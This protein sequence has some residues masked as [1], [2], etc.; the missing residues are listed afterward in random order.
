MQITSIMSITR[1]R[2]LNE[3]MCVYP[4]PTKQQNTFNAENFCVVIFPDITAHFSTIER[5]LEFNK[6]VYGLVW[7]R[8]KLWC[9]AVF[10]CCFYSQ[11]SRF[12]SHRPGDP[13]SR[14]CLWMMANLSAHSNLIL[15]RN[16]SRVLA[17]ATSGQK[18]NLIICW[19]SLTVIY[20]HLLKLA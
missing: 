14:S 3:I 15:C 20:C 18:T 13:A 10:C 7:A 5:L 2:I 19:G 16:S 11:S 4:N 1:V 9:W 6:N 17:G 8:F 12:L